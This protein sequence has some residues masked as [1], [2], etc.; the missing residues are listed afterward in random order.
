MT[1]REKV[2][3]NFNTAKSG[4]E[5]LMRDRVLI[6]GYRNLRKY[7]LR[8]IGGIV[9]G[10]QII[11]FDSRQEAEDYALD[12]LRPFYKKIGKRVTINMAA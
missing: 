8:V 6:E 12:E 7:M 2:M 11:D 4:A 10:M 3:E 9:D 5:K 1:M